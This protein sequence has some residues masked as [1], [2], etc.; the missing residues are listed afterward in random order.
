MRSI[1]RFAFSIAVALILQAPIARAAPGDITNLGTLGGNFSQAYDIND[2]GVVV[3]R[4]RNASNTYRAFRYSGAGPMEDLGNNFGGNYAEAYAINS[5]G[6]IAG[7]ADNSSG[8]LR[9]F[10]LA[11]AG[12]MEDLGSFG[13]TGGVA[14]DVNDSGTVVGYAYNPSSDNRP[15]RYVGS[16]PMEDLG[17]L[18]GSDADANA[19]NNLGVIVGESSLSGGGTRAFRYTGSGP[20]DNLGTLGGN[21]TAQAINDAGTIVGY[22]FFSG[23]FHA[24]RYS[25]SGPM[26]DLGT[27]G[28]T[29]SAAYDINDQG[30]IAGYAYSA[31]GVFPAA[32]WRPDGSIVNL[33]AWLDS[34]NPTEGARWRLD[35]AQ[36]INNSGLIAGY[37]LFDTN[38]DG[39]VNFFDETRAFVL[40]AGTLVP[41]PCALWAATIALAVG[42]GRRSPRRPGI[43]AADRTRLVRV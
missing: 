15:F 3:G 38:N 7:Y 8:R 21:S 4:A 16:G 32:L 29:S 2:S 12:P 40:D 20:M 23:G 9:A 11:G 13:G 34:V 6:T 39:V 42:L 10:R 35:S 19:I 26:Q 31:P 17:T 24:F 43:P 28:G 41:E 18:G 30:F 14:L 33:D 1:C 5:S 37:G 27:L 36:A 25:G 22:F